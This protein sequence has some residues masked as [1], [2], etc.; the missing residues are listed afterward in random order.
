MLSG[1]VH[2]IFFEFTS[3]ECKFRNLEAQHEIRDITSGM[4]LV[5][6]GEK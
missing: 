2:E 4:I 6:S 3:S 1:F 5:V